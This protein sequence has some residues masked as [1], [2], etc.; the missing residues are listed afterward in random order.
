M[1]NSPVPQISGSGANTIAAT[2][3]VQH[4]LNTY[5]YIWTVGEN[6]G[7]QTFSVSTGTDLAGNVVEETLTSGGSILIDIL[8]TAALSYTIS[9]TAVSSTVK[10][11]DEVLI[12]ATFNKDMADSPVVQ[13]YAEGLNEMSPS[14]MTKINSTSYTYTITV[15]SGNG[16][17]YF[18]MAT[19]TDLAGTL[20][21][22]Y[23]TSGETLIID[24]TPPTIT[25]LGD[26]TV[27]IEVG[28]IYTDAGADADDNV[29]GPVI[30]D[31]IV[32][33]ST[34]NTSVIGNYTV[35]YNVSDAAGNAATQVTRTVNV[36]ADQTSPVI[37]LEGANPQSIELGTAYS[38]LGAT[39]T[40]NIDGDISTISV[41]MQRMYM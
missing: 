13:I 22:T 28:A 1:A 19:G 5:K 18:R 31:N 35:T 32:A 17:Q 23:P 37:T 20:I 8:P 10:Q 33:V 38:E 24:N 7:T 30:T 29:D 3:L 25:L 12:T 26:P 9:G 41:L 21:E 16:N 6:T 27:N 36:T 15:G 4:Y 14:D 11:G 39:A 2:D 34:V 40:D